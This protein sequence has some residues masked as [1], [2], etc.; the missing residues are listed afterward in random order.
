MTF[1]FLR[2]FYLKFTIKAN[3]VYISI[4]AEIQHAHALITLVSILT[5]GLWQRLPD[6]SDLNSLTERTS[7][8]QHLRTSNDTTSAVKHPHT[9]KSAG[10]RYWLSAGQF[11][12]SIKLWYIMKVQVNNCVTLTLRW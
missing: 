7:H 4:W 10:L 3:I 2:A 8:T 1:I 5:V 12:K 6:L 11:L 9:E